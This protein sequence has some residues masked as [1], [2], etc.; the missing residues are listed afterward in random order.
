MNTI[1]IYLSIMLVA[2]FTLISFLAALNGYRASMEEAEN[3]M[4]LQ[5]KNTSNILLLL[6]ENTTPSIMDV[7]AN[8]PF[9]FQ[10]WHNDKL[11][12]RSPL[13]PETMINTAENGFSYS[14]F[15]GYRWRT[16]NLSNEENYHV[17]VAERADLRHLFAEKVVLESI[18]PLILW[19]PISALLVWFLIGV[20]LRP[21]RNLSEQINLKRS[22]DLHP[23]DYYNP[24]KELVQLIDSTNSLLARLSASFERE[25]HFAA[26]AAHELRTPI[27]ILKVHMHNLATELSTDNTSLTHAN[28]G[29]E[30]MQHL[31]EQILDLNRSNPEI[32]E[33]DFQTLDL[34]A[35]LK[36]IT[37]NAWPMFAEKNQN[38]SLLGE[39]VSIM[40]DESMLEI[41]AQNLLDNA[42]KYTPN[43]GDIEIY[44]GIDNDKAVLKIID[45][46][47][48][49]PADKLTQVFQR[50]YRI[51]DHDSKDVT[52]SGLGLAIVQ[53]IVK[54]HSADIQ[55]TAGHKNYGLSVQI[56]FPLSGEH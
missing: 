33:A 45:S 36:R 18:F 40:G 46:G 48:G 49:I 19:L 28:A 30:R 34:H 35:L 55:L 25:K 53:Q 37:A 22:E 3:L 24:P 47:K 7:T 14:N 31:V 4:D 42:S 6:S 54:L 9:S 29:I 21:L 8:S 50:F 20:G 44:T 38:I 26:H 39:P 16:L 5:L 13:A 52:G 17:I 43:E 12:L 27:S 56:Y 2:A 32:L 15:S 11:L 51:T 41:L 10:L 1:R 23:I